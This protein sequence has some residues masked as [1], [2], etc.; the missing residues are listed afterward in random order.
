MPPPHNIPS[1]F[2]FHSHLETF[3]T[4]ENRPNGHAPQPYTYMD[5]LWNSAPAET[6]ANLG[7]DSIILN[8]DEPSTQPPTPHQKS[9]ELNIYLYYLALA[10]LSPTPTSAKLGWDSFIAR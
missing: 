9:I 3:E 1:Q 6:P 2:Q 10:K 7:W 5:I 4:W 8:W